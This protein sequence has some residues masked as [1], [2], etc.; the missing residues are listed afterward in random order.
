MP[1]FIYKN[2]QQYGPY[3][4]AQI[5]EW[6]RMG[7]CSPQD[8]G[9]REGMTDWQPL[10]SVL[11]ASQESAQVS[12]PSADPTELFQKGLQAGQF[13]N[14]DAALKM[15]DACLCNNP[16]LYIEVQAFWN[17]AVAIQH[18]FNFADRPGSS[19]SNAEMRWLGRMLKCAQNVVTI[20]ETRLAHEVLDEDVTGVLTM[21]YRNAKEL[22]DG[23]RYVG[24]N[25]GNKLRDFDEVRR[26]YVEPLFCLANEEKAEAAQ[27]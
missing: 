15:F 5:A 14:N 11:A 2:K 27:Q 17:L 18:K 23:Y 25:H 10:A 21:I 24:V 4:D 20:S 1:I 19:L 13:G 22:Y 8:Y 9:W 3:D 7:Q 12:P 16:P 6:L 26:V